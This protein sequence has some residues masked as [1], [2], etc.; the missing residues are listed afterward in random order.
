MDVEAWSSELAL[1][2]IA[3]IVV[4]DGVGVSAERAHHWE[5][6]IR[7]LEPGAD[8]VGH[9]SCRCR[10]VPSVRGERARKSGAVIEGGVGSESASGEW[11]MV[12]GDEGSEGVIVR[13]G[14]K[15]RSCKSDAVI[16]RGAGSVTAF[17]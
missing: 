17:N 2:V 5:R 1:V 4:A 7:M 9:R 14:C 12:R 11:R 13:V 16:V 8:G 15:C 6:R 10:C 3:M